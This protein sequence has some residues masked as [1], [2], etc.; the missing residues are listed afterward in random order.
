MKTIVVAALLFGGAPI[1][2]LAQQDPGPRGGPAGAGN[3]IAGLN[4]QEAKFFDTARGAFSEIE[5][6]ESGLGP[7]FN[8]DSCGGCHSQ[9]A[10]GGTSP[11]VN[12]QIAAASKNGARNT[13]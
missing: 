8:S 12:P 5:D 11:A 2:A 10:I 1:I 13:I 3:P 7:R 4:N 6:V 9:P